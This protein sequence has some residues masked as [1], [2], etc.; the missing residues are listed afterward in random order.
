MIYQYDLEG[1]LINKFNTTKEIIP[2][3]MDGK[4]N[5]IAIRTNINNCLRGGN[6]SAYGY[7]WKTD[8]VAKERKKRERVTDD[9]I[10]TELR[11]LQDQSKS[12]DAYNIYFFYE[13]QA[14]KLEQEI[15]RKYKDRFEIDWYPYT[16]EPLV[17]VMELRK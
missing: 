4:R 5:E 8:R 16:L 10:Q 11:A 1:K 12:I 9:F 2:L 17:F 7:V 15:K 14:E 3:F 13:E 6:L